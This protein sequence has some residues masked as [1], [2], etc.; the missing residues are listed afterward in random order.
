MADPEELGSK[1]NIILGYEKVA[2]IDNKLGVIGTKVD[3]LVDAREDDRRSHMDHEV[4]LRS[5]ELTLAGVIAS[6]SSS[7]NVWVWVFGAV[8]SAV[9]IGVGLLNYFK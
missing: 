3:A 8:V 1:R 9:T 4:R 5:L 6:G 2:E 7:K